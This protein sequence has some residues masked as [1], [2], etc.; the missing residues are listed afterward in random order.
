M[1]HLT[2]AAAGRKRSALAVPGS[3]GSASGKVTPS[4]RVKS[5]TDPLRAFPNV[6]SDR[7]VG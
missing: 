4:P 1:H 3:S 6:V 5:K 7:P 2:L